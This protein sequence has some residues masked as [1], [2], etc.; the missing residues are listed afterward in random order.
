MDNVLL[1]P[2]SSMVKIYVVVEIICT[3][4]TDFQ[5]RLECGSFAKRAAEM[6]FSGARSI[7]NVELLAM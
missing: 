5:R 6:S 4:P 7:N 2:S 3:G 1:M